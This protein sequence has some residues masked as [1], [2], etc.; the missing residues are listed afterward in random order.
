MTCDLCYIFRQ[1]GP[2]QTRK[3][4]Y[5]TC[6]VQKIVAR[7]LAGI[8]ARILAR[9]LARS[10]GILAL[11]LIIFNVNFLCVHLCW[12]NS[13][14]YL[15]SNVHK[16]CPLAWFWGVIPKAPFVL[17]NCRYMNIQ[18]TRTSFSGQVGTNL[19]LCR[20]VCLFHG[21]YD[22][23]RAYGNYL[24]S[25]CCFETGTWQLPMFAEKNYCARW[26]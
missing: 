12:L 10:L 22:K 11:Y 19:Y 15:S 16:K 26:A 18:L 24:V 1:L 9:I 2:S 25:L 4:G 23:S 20:A 3:L 21:T 5:V 6:H 8:Q 14:T 7:I 17:K 13:V